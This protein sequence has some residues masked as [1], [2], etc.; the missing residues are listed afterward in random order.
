MRP[1]GQAGLGGAPAEA[2]AEERR[3]EDA[4]N[5]I[6]CAPRISSDQGRQREQTKRFAGGKRGFRPGNK[7]CVRMVFPVVLTGGIVFAIGRMAGG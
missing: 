5:R 6:R 1:P 2:E 7:D 4:R 3:A